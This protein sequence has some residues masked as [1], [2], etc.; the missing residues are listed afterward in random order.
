MGEGGEG[1]GEEDQVSIKQRLQ[2]ISM[3]PWVMMM[4]MKKFMIPWKMMIET[5]NLAIFLEL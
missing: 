2:V 4:M 3:I 5:H 1:G